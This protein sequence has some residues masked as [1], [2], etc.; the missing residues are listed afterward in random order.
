M[1]MSHKPPHM[2]ASERWS[3]GNGRWLRTMWLIVDGP[4]VYEPLD[5]QDNM[6]HHMQTVSPSS[7]QQTAHV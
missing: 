6:H 1:W 2:L 3:S 7:S 5:M 4:L